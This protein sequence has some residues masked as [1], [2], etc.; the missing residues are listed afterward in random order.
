MFFLSSP[1]QAV[2]AVDVA[3]SPAFETGTPRLLFKPPNGTFAP[4]QLSN[5]ATH[6]GQRFVFLVQLPPVQTP[7]STGTQR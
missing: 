7:A 4:A 2:M 5:V 1:E 3:A 6:D